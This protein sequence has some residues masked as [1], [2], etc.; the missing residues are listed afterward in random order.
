[1]ELDAPVGHLAHQLAALEFGHGREPRGVVAGDVVF[2]GTYD[3]QW[4][5]SE[6]TL[7][8]LDDATIA[9]GTGDDFTMTHDGTTTTLS[10][11]VTWAN[12]ISGQKVPFEAVTAS[13]NVLTAAESGLV[14][15]VTYTGSHTT[16][17]PQAAA[18]LTFTV[19]DN[20][21]TAADDVIVD[22]QA[23]DNIEGDSNGDGLICTDDAVGSS[24]TLVA[25]SATRW[26]VLSTT[27][28][29]AAQ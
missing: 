12:T 18:G 6:N 22:I 19:I 24:V 9:V 20:S 3:I 8:V 14:T 25:V 5:D 21:A 13:T 2:D 23:G 27:G 7:E 10:G 28:T 15:T 11:D 4:D 26:V 17:L 1:M 29:W 16:T